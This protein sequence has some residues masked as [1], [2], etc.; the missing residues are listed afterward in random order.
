[1][2]RDSKA[3]CSEAGLGSFAWVRANCLATK[4]FVLA[5]LRRAIA[6]F[7]EGFFAATSCAEGSCAEGFF[8]CPSLAGGLL[9]FASMRR[10]SLLPLLRRA[11]VAASLRRA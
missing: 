5:S 9:L 2:W 3:S 1:M 11:F 4:G 6:T 10:A 7:A 8:A